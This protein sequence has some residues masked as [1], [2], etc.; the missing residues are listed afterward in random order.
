MAKPLALTDQIEQGQQSRFSEDEVMT[1]KDLPAES[2][3]LCAILQHHTTYELIDFLA[4]LQV[5]VAACMAQ[6]HA[7][8]QMV[9]SWPT[10]W[11]LTTS[12]S[13]KK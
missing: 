13:S 5:V 1:F 2:H 9:E 11:N 4:R 10:K 7:E 3:E 12:P 6:G 8:H